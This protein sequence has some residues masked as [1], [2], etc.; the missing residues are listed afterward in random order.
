MM[1]DGQLSR[2]LGSGTYADYS[3]LKMR[4]KSKEG[5]R[6]PASEMGDIFKLLVTAQSEFGEYLKQHTTEVENETPSIGKFRTFCNSFSEGKKIV[7]HFFDLEKYPGWI[8]DTETNIK[9]VFVERI[10][11]FC[12]YGACSDLLRVE[13]LISEPGLYSDHDDELPTFSKR[14]EIF[15]KLYAEANP[16]LKDSTSL[17]GFKYAR[18]P[19]QNEPSA[20]GLCNSFFGSCPG[21]PFLPYFRRYMG[22]RYK[23]IVNDD[24]TYR[25]QDY[26][27]M[28]GPVNKDD[29]TSLFGLCTLETTGPSA[30]ERAYFAAQKSKDPDLGTDLSCGWMRSVKPRSNRAWLQN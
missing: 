13:L 18:L 1:T 14:A 17:C 30:L 4:I 23:G 2:M 6:I 19:G 11:R 16:I 15:N 22:E 25:G 29:V 3:N 26:A 5:R 20:K 21:H 12:N 9:W 24:M 28:P 27:T 10:R 7:L 8:R